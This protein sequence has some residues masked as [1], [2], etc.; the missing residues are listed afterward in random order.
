[1]FTWMVG[2]A[3]HTVLVIVVFGIGSLPASCA[4]LN[5]WFRQPTPPGLPRED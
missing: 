5:A 3:H 2:A 1:M 4:A